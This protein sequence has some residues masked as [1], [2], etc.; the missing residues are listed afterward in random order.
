MKMMREGIIDGEKNMNKG[1][2]EK[3]EEIWV[4]YLIK[5]ECFGLEFRLNRRE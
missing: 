1:K 4:I 2:K 5:L 3:W